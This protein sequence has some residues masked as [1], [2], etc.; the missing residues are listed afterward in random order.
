MIVDDQGLNLKLMS[1]LLKRYGFNT[2][3]VKDGEIALEKL[4]NGLPDLILLDILMPGIN[5]FEIC[6]RL[7]SSEI[8]VIKIIGI[9]LVFSEDCKRRQISKPLIPGMSTSNKIKSGNPFFSFSS[10]ISPFSTAITLKPDIFNKF[11]MT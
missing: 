7:Q 2:I 5:G 6:R 11:D 4:K 3:V 9:F 8:E 1:N 10:A